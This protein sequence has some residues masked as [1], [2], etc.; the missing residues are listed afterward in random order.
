MPAPT[1]I[2]VEKLRLDAF[3]AIY[4]RT[5]TRCIKKFYNNYAECTSRQKSIKYAEKERGQKG[6]RPGLKRIYVF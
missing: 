6:V 1:E 4:S 5:S 3:E 2:I